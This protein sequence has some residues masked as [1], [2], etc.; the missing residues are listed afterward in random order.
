MLGILSSSVMQM[1]V[2]E[3]DVKRFD[4]L[5]GLSR[6]PGAPCLG[7]ELAWY[8]NEAES[9]LGVLLLDIVDNDYVS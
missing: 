7:Q 5:A 1:K 6:S 4:A 3:L 9:I 2:R 8:S